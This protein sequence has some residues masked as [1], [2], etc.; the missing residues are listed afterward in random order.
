M[1]TPSSL[2]SDVMA[3]LRGRLVLFGNDFPSDSL[4]DLFRR[5]HRWSKDK[6]FT[7]LALSLEESLAVIREEV[8][9]LSQPVPDHVACIQNIVALVDAWEPIRTTP[10]GGAI[11]SALLC[12][13]QVGILIGCVPSTPIVPG[14]LTS[15]VDLMK[16]QT[17]T[18]ICTSMEPSSVD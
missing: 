18:M 14:M 8:N 15:L 13:L 17:R 9:K 6:R 16:P 3:S 4:I 7:V 12:V 2:S 10:V 1:D 11:E 5:L